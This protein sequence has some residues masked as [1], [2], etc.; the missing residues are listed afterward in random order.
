[1]EVTRWVYVEQVRGRGRGASER[2]RKRQQETPEREQQRTRCDAAT[3]ATQS[4]R[5]T[6]NCKRQHKRDATR[7]TREKGDERP[8][9]REGR[10]A[11][12]ALKPPAFAPATFGTRLWHPP[13]HG[14]GTGARAGSP[15]LLSSL[16]SPLALLLATGARPPSLSPIAL[17]S[18]GGRRATVASAR[19]RRQEEAASLAGRSP[20]NPCRPLPSA[21][22]RTQHT[23]KTK[24]RHTSSLSLVVERKCKD[25]HTT[26]V[27]E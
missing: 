3:G 24:T 14:L 5:N 4:E 20:S 15:L 18:V 13:W 7:G 9:K 10:G 27:V 6:S 25:K 17:L 2:E 8:H 16:L 22:L 26:H 19:L 11:P 23:R 12:A 1:M 21:P